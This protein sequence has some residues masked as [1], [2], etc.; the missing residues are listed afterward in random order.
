MLLLRPLQ[1]GFVSM[2]KTIP[3]RNCHSVKILEAIKYNCQGMNEDNKMKSSSAEHLETI[4]GTIKLSPSRGERR[5]RVAICHSNFCFPVAAGTF[6]VGFHNSCHRYFLKAI[7]YGFHLE[8]NTLRS[9]LFAE[10]HSW[11]LSHMKKLLRIFAKKP[12][13]YIKIGPLY[14]LSAFKFKFKVEELY[15]FPN[16]QSSQRIEITHPESGL[17]M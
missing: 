16:P 13:F 14:Q 11:Q 2:G 1:R 12:L 4:T 9:L 17:W 10:N 7:N 3:D 15:Y 5:R 6:L 8:H